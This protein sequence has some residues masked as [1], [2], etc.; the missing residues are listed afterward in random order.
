MAFYIKLDGIEGE[1]PET[2]HKG[3][4]DVD[5]FSYT[6][7]QEVKMIKGGGLSAGRAD[8]GSLAFT[9]NVDKTSPNLV[10][11]CASGKVMK[12]V[13]FHAVKTTG[14][15]QNAEVYI[16]ITL[17]NAV[18]ASVSPGGGGGDASVTEHVSLAY[19]EFKIAYTEQ[20]SDGSLGKTVTT[21]WDIK[22]NTAKA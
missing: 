17:T 14:N 6:V 3:W 4:I 2:K 9:H 10:Q 5:N 12:T 16:D 19:E 22:N 21:G 15:T 20:K 11:Y 7:N 1:C 18:I 8:F 13:N